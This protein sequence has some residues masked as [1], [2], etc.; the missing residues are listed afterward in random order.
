M[1]LFLTHIQQVVDETKKI[2]GI[3]NQLK[4][5]FQSIGNV[6]SKD[7]LDMTVKELATWADFFGLDFKLSFS[8][9]NLKPETPKKVR[10]K[11]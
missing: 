1:K 5:I 8:N 4:H 6:S 3:E 7:P 10:H 11:I 9:S 2:Q